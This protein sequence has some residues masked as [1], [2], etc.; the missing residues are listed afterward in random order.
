[1][2][3]SE[4]V[5]LFGL[6]IVQARPVPFGR[7]DP[8]E[9]S[10]IFV[11]SALVEG[12]VKKPL[13]FHVHNLALIVKIAGMEDKLRRHDLLVSEEEIAAFYEK[14]LPGIYDIRTLQRLIR[15][16]GDDAFL[17]MKEEDLLSRPPDS[18][19]IAQYPESIASGGWRLECLYRF[20]PG[21]PEDGIT[22]KIPVQAVPAVEA[23]AL[24]WEVP[25]LLRQKVAALLRGLPKEFRKRLQ[26]LARTCE[27]ILQE[28]PREGAL[29]TA[30]G[31]FLYERFGV[32]IPADRWPLEALE[33]HLKIRFSI[34]DGKDREVASGRDAA[35]LCQG[36]SDPEEWRALAR[37]RK[38]WEKKGL[39][40]W[41]FG[42]LPERVSPPGGG[43]HAPVA[44]PALSV[45]ESGIDLRLFPSAPEAL[46][47]H[48]RGV[49]ALIALRFREELKHLR[50]GVAPGGE[51][52]LWAAAFGGAKALENALVEKV[53]HVLFE[54][55]V[56]TAAAFE[57]HA[58]R[59]RPEI[60]P[61][62]QAALR[63]AGPPLKALYE[64]A[65]ELRTLAGANRGNRLVLA[66]LEE[67]REELSRLLPADFLVRYDGERIEQLGRYFRALILRAR[68]G[69]V[70]LEKAIE[71]GKEVRA[72]AA[73]Q[74]EAL[75]ALPPYASEEKRRALAEFAW[76][77]EEYKISL[78]AQEI[79]TAFPVSRKRLEAR[80][81]E[82]QRML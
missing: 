65:E 17:R 73:W 9:A 61:R 71:R 1:V 50:K 44:F 29:P 70:H 79:K 76:M 27:V 48:R 74:E 12:E 51:L 41:D 33:E 8:E 56:R 81:G 14:R 53:M 11:R 47:S 55:D 23:P 3:A 82:I 36:F 78:F 75:R 22:L 58:E 25:G 13:P 54:A 19:E 45:S 69:A 37:L 24:D 18:E 31:R 66:F 46:L 64:A 63:T 62:G 59:I 4:Q 15:D 52:K 34:V 42:N 49:R 80:M 38:S 2:V 32:D 39:V 30:L 72:L 67:L 57:A 10:R 40:A 16:R 35:I 5:T 7:I 43:P 20:D 6:V 21:K 68:R 28:M 77:I 26:P 60:L